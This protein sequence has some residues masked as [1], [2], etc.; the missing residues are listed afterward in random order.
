VTLLTPVRVCHVMTADLWAGAEVQLAT[1]AS[2]LVE[3]DDIEL[4][5]VLFN[6]G[7]LA[8]ELRR[9]G[10]AVEIVDEQR[11]S[12]MRI[13]ARLARVLRR[14]RID[15]VHTHRGKDNVLGS[16]AAVLAGVPRIVRTVHGLTE[17]MTGW[18]RLR[19]GVTEAIDKA[20]LRCRADRI[21]AVS[22]ATAE[23]LGRSGYP[24][25]S[26]VT[27]HNGVDLR[28]VAA[29][30]TPSAVRAALGIPAEAFVVGTA[31]RLTAVKAQDDLIRAA[32][33]ISAAGP[34][35]RVVLIG[36]GPEEAR[37]RGLARELGVEQ[38]SVFVDPAADQ[39]AGI[40]DLIGALDVFALPSL[41]EGVP[42]A[43][44]EAMA[45]ERPAVASSVGGIPEIVTDR[46]TGLLVPPRDPRA[47]ADACLA[48]ARNR[49]WA[50]MTGI[51]A[52]RSVEASFSRERN[53]QALA[54]LYTGLVR[55]AEN[56]Y[57][58]SAAA[59]AAAPIRAVA[60]RIARKARRLRGLRQA[61][62]LRRNP[63]AVAAA[64]A[65]ART[66]LV[67]CHGNIIRS[68]F[69]ERLMASGVAGRCGISIASA[70]LAAER[71]RTSP[72]FAVAAA[73]PRRVDLR[74]HSARPLTAADVDAADAIFVMDVDQQ[75]AL[76]RAHPPAA[77]KVFLL[78][79]LAADTPLE[80]H[81]PVDDPA[82]VFEACYEHIA[83]AVLP[84]VRILA[85]A[86]P[87]QS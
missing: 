3:R 49:S 47:L 78:A 60:A 6:D 19:Y 61:E 8:A 68:P 35:V 70:G 72:A 4:S 87:L 65:R 66:V 18:P 1:A 81:D 7:W 24:R 38:R 80:V 14:R 73:A 57:R 41:S 36:S 83:R 43:L 28:T 27:I 17:P 33:W 52:R 2:Y 69:A 53:G 5:A 34:D 37:L 71:G 21:V 50:R 48:F 11:C 56:P 86:G 29:E 74:D 26:I 22:R 84:I 44:L 30:Q 20:V 40:Y 59:I 79:S 32:A 13:V 12:A 23:A 54:A 16:I 64:L 25:A 45:L 10:V 39:R 75:L 15:L 63:A 85:S 46:A 77:G 55:P 42:M 51:R 9:L 62:R 31:G 58:V 67:V 82:P 76:E